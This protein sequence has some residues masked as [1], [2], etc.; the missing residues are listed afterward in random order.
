LAADCVA[1]AHERL[2][3]ATCGTSRGSGTSS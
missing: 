2:A 3:L 1:V